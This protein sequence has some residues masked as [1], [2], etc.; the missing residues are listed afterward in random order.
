MNSHNPLLSNTNADKYLLA[1]ISLTH[2]R[3]YDMHG[4]TISSFFISFW[5]I[6]SNLMK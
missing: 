6:Q 4:L 3:F 1:Y 2:N 5:F